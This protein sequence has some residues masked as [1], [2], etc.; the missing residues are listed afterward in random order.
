MLGKVVRLAQTQSSESLFVKMR[1]ASWLVSELSE[2]FNLASFPDYQ[3]ID[4]P[5]L[6]RRLRFDGVV[7][8]ENNRNI[9]VVSRGRLEAAIAGGVVELVENSPETTEAPAD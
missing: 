3:R 4:N 1:Q 2:G 5:V 9:I 8:V 6:M 7:G